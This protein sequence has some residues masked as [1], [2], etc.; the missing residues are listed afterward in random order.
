MDSLK[1]VNLL[2]LFLVI[3]CLVHYKI[4]DDFASPIK[5]PLV[6]HIMLDEGNAKNLLSVLLESSLPFNGRLLPS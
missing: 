6:V 4:V 1:A 5:I 3:I 2:P